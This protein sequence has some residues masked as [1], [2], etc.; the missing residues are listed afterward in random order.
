MTRTSHRTRCPFCFSG[1]VFACFSHDHSE[2]PT[3]KS[4]TPASANPVGCRSSDRRSHG[5]KPG[6]QCAF[7][8]SM[9][10]YLQ[11]TLIHAVGCVLHRST[12]RVIHRSELFCRFCLFQNQREMSVFRVFRVK[13]VTSRGDR[14]LLTSVNQKTDG[15]VRAAPYTETR[16]R[17]RGR[18]SKKNNRRTRTHTRAQHS[19]D[20]PRG[21][22]GCHRAHDADALRARDRAARFLQAAQSAAIGDAPFTK[23]RRRHRSEFFCCGWFVTGIDDTRWTGAAASRDNTNRSRGDLAGPSS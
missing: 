9:F 2:A 23:T 7:E 15:P 13:G 4:N 14:S 5:L 3:V 17:T 12:S 8:T 18:S 21:D 20:S 10:C 16:W 11:F 6:P 1:S 19:T 22:E